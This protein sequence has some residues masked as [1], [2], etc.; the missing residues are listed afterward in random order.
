MCN[1]PTVPRWAVFYLRSLGVP[2]QAARGLLIYA[3]I[4]E[5]VGATSAGAAPLTVEKLVAY[6]LATGGDES[7]STGPAMRCTASQ[8][9]AVPSP[10]TAGSDAANSTQ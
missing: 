9:R 10:A 7:T 4:H 8:L 5:T 3:F 1:A 2:H 6:R